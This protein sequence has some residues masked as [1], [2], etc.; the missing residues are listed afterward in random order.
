MT[1]RAPWKT[2]SDRCARYLAEAPRSLRNHL[3]TEELIR[4]VL[5]ALSTGGGIFGILLAIVATAGS[6][7]PSPADAGLA[8][9]VLTAIIE[10]RRRLGHGTEADARQSR[11]QR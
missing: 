10:T 5:A 1:M 11:S 3:N 6:I 7:F 8:A 4:V 9:A 2:L